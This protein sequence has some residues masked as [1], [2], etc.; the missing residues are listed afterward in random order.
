MVAYYLIFLV[1][2]TLVYSDHIYPPILFIINTHHHHPH[3]QAI[4]AKTEQLLLSQYSQGQELPDILW[5]S[6][7]L[8]QPEADSAWAIYPVC[9][10]AFHTF[11]FNLFIL[12]FSRVLC[13]L[14]IQIS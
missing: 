13:W 7:D 6:R 1:Q 14:P 10:I 12:P 5:T 9:M 4:A 2:Y 8:Q 3:H 11:A